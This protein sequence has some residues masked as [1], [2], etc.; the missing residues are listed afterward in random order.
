M[1]SKLSEL[2]CM[3]PS[4]RTPQ[5]YERMFDEFICSVGGSRVEDSFT[6]PAGK[7]NADYWVE[8]EGAELILELKQLAKYVPTKTVSDYFSDL[9]NDGAVR[10][11]SP[12][13]PGVLRVGPESLSAADWDRF[14]RKFRPSVESSLRHAAIQLK[15]TDGFIPR[16][17]KRRF[18]GA[19]FLNSGDFNLPTDLLFRLVER[20]VKLEWK[21]GKYGALDFVSCATIDMFSSEV[22]P[23]H[24]R[25]IARSTADRELVAT[26]RWLYEAWLA[27]VGSVVGFVVE[28]VAE[29]EV[30]E[31]R[32]TSL[33]APF[34]G[35][36]QWHRGG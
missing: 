18:R 10:S 35:K 24:A 28:K 27:Y 11:A 21:G 32:F 20:K 29:K 6:V 13:S 22:H 15:D 16:G 2:L 23:L 12:V 4:E 33:S 26:V 25:H 34:V 30:A 19:F 5:I 17:G 36:I 7:K 1:T 3:P 31:T 14:Y 8:F 9:I